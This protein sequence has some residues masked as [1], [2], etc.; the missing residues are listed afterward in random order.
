MLLGTCGL[1]LMFIH[2]SAKPRCFK[3]M[4]INSLPMHYYSQKKAW[5]DSTLFESWF[6]DRFVPYAKKFC[7]DNSIKYKILLLLDNAPAHLSVEILQSKD[8]RV[9]TMFLPP[10]TTSITKPMDQGIL[11]AMKRRYKKCI[12]HHLIL[13]NDTSSL[14]L[15]KNLKQLTIKDAVYW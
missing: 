1:P 12:L 8:G 13:E 10:N 6:H 5:M 15:P 3:Y 2:T 7:Q 9:N 14:T 11:E 4:D